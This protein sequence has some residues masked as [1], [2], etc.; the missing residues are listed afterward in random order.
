[1]KRTESKLSKQLPVPHFPPPERLRRLARYLA[2]IWLAGWL[3][4]GQLA[5][6]ADLRAARQELVKSAFS[7]FV[8]TYSLL[9]NGSYYHH[10]YP[11]AAGN[12]YYANRGLFQGSLDYEGLHYDSL[13]IGY[14]L[15]NQFVFVS[16]LQYGTQEQLI[17]NTQKISRFRAGQTQ[18]VRVP[19]SAYTE[20]E[21]G[22]YQLVYEGET[23]RFLIRLKKELVKIPSSERGENQF[24]FV[25]KESY[26][27]AGD[28][29]AYQLR[30]R[31][32][33]IGAFGS[34]PR[35]VEFVK[36]NKLY[37]RAGQPGFVNEVVQVLQFA[38]EK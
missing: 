24:K 9:K 38:E 7:T 5:A 11:L 26:Y 6:Q 37:L 28:L 17:L 15:H 35:I 13:P 32:D 20:L 14:D 22:I 19:D 8:P 10:F 12:Q 4:A 31:K 1:M 29:T 23:F 2:C 21:G 34:D 27:L 36:R 25:E 33:L 3:A 30:R 18:F 16:V